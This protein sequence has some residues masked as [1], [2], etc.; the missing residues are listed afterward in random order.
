M[1]AG[2]LDVR[3][4]QRVGLGGAVFQL[5]GDGEGGFDGQRGEGGDEQLPDLL[6]KAG[7]GDGLAD[8]AAVRDAVA[9]A[10]VGGDFLVMALVVA[11][12]H[13]LPQV[14]QMMMPC[15]SAGPSRG[16]PAV[17][18]LPCAAALAARRARL[19]SY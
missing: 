1:V 9:L 2:A 19:A 13:A 17:R 12:G 16:G 3:G 8:P 7:A 4:A 15:R 6:V 14:P 5:G 18:S 11:D 10:H